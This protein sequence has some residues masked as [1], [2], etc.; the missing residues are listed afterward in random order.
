MPLPARAAPQQ[1]VTIA[2]RAVPQ[3]PELPGTPVTELDGGGP[4]LR[5]QGPLRALGP[6]PRGA[7]ALLSGGPGA[8]KSSACFLAASRCAS[9]WVLEL[10]MSDKLTR[11]YAER[12][13][14]GESVIVGRD[15]TRML[16]A[17]ERGM[18]PD[19]IVVDSAGRVLRSELIDLRQACQRYGVVLVV[20]VQVTRDGELSGG[21]ALEHDIGDATVWLESVDGR[22]GDVVVRKSRF[23]PGGHFTRT[24]RPKVD[25]Q[26]LR[27]RSSDRSSPNRRFRASA[28]LRARA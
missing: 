8:G 15:L 20:I 24:G 14:A 11:Q 21:A 1:A 22:P 12:A 26:A 28:P 17:L 5:L 27:P 19:L 23:G 7:C 13:K 6:I 10:E 9:A 25:R 18:I 16:R 3:P 2:E 4:C